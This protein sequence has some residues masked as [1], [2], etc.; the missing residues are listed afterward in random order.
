MPPYM[1]HFPS[2]CEAIVSG[3]YSQKYGGTDTDKYSLY[4]IRDGRVFNSSAWYHEDQLEEIKDHK[5]KDP[6]EMIEDF[7]FRYEN[8]S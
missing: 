8:N 3:T 6:E 7:N 4:L 1:S 2:D 5:Y